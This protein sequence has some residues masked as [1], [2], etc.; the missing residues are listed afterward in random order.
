[1]DSQDLTHFLRRKEQRRLD[2]ARMPIEE[3]V[4]AVV[5]LQEMAA[6]ILR[7]RGKS[8]RI[9]VIEQPVPSRQ[10]KRAL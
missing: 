10:G 9:W 8:V 6:P 3:K 5:R 1:M 7:Q 4:L 2:L